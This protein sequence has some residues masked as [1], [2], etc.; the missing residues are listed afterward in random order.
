MA[1]GASTPVDDRNSIPDNMQTIHI[2]F[3]IIE[4]TFTVMKMLTKMIALG[5]AAA[6][7]TVSAASCAKNNAPLIG[8]SQFGEHASLD[9]CREGFL[10]GLKEAG[11]EEGKDFTV[12][13]QNAGFD[14]G[15]AAQIAQSF[16]AED[17]ALMCAIA[18]PSATACYA[19]AE[20]KNIPVIFTA[21]TDP[22]GAN[23]TGGN[24]TGTSDLLPVE[25]QLKLIRALQPD[26]KKIGILY[27]TSEPN[28][29]YTISQ[30][31]ALA[32]QYSFEIVAVGVS[33]QSEVVAAAADVLSRGVDCLSNLTDNTVVGVLASIL[34]VTNEAK[35]PVYGSE[36][37]QIKLGCVAGAGLDY[38]DL[39]KQTGMM[40]AK[41]L[42]GEASASEIPYETITEYGLFLN[43]TVAAELGI[44]VPETL[45]FKEIY[46]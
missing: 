40:A 34:Q 29:I 24:I 15:I 39:G 3:T 13:Y 2:E 12:D 19:A 26:A 33:T 28:S 27:T 46:R 22:V 14:G 38:F 6:A 10:A 41:I 35:I 7:L 25:G 1:Q 4:R 18:T 36:Q 44:T 17:A 43:E 20:D 32:A 8:I 21:I 30:Y 23:L 42:R 11:L 31:E 37:E 16:S 5:L 9:N 45:T